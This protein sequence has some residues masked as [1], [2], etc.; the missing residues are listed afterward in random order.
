MS[1]IKFSSTR[2]LPTGKKGIIKP[3]ANGYYTTILGGLNCYNSA[4]AYYPA[5]DEVRK[6]FEDSSILM[7]RIKKGVLKAELGHPKQTPGMSDMDYYQR[8]MDIDEKCVC[9]HISEIWLDEEFGKNHP[10]Y[11]N[12]NLIAI[13]GRV[14]PSGPY[15]HV[16]KRSMENPEENSCFSIRSITEDRWEHGRVNKT[17]KTI[18]CWD[19][20]L[21]PGL[22]LATK[23]DSPA[24][25][26]FNNNAVD[27]T[28]LDKIISVPDLK[29]VIEKNAKKLKPGLESDDLI[30]SIKSIIEIKPEEKLPAYVNWE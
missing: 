13:V 10:E 3:D 8:I 24:L 14:A 30:Y 29:R 18:V 16:L 2:I 1:T 6:L 15:G 21:E 28:D 17:I 4:G 25:E 19:M 9:A 11:N 22:A 23:Y 26:S 20:V 12:P 27:N 7:R 5:S